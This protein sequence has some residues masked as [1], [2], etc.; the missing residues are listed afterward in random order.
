M[1]NASPQP[2]SPL[3][4][5]IVNDII[6]GALPFGSRVTIDNLAERYGSSHMPV[7]EALRELH[8][9]GLLVMETQS[10]S[11]HK[12]RRPRICRLHVRYA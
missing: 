10:W 7:C 11:A 4:D 12:A 3:R 2:T 9:E 6:S 5:R 8:G 1:V